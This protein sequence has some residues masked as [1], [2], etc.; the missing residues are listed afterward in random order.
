MAAVT[1]VSTENTLS[2]KRDGDAAI[3]SDDFPADRV[4]LLSG[5][6]EE[7]VQTRARRLAS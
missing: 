4:I 7:D 6:G 1:T 5:A 3:A 2:H